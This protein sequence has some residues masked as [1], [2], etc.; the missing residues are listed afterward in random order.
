MLKHE[1]AALRGMRSA[2]GQTPKEDW[3]ALLVWVVCLLVCVGVFLS[4]IERLKHRH[5]AGAGDAPGGNAPDGEAQAR[6]APRSGRDM[7]DPPGELV[8]LFV[9]VGCLPACFSV[10]L[11]ALVRFCQTLSGS[12]V[13]I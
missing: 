1:L 12:N 10:Y 3:V 11:F 6:R 8:A 4:N 7:A 13:Q 5:F 9:W 2:T